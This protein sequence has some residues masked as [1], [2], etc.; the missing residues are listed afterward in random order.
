MIARATFFI[1]EMEQEEKKRKSDTTNYFYGPIGQYIERVEHNHFGMSSDGSFQYGDANSEVVQRKLFPDLPTRD[2]MISAVIETV[3]EGLWWSN[4]S[5]AIVYRIYQ[6]KGYMGGFSQFVR[7]VK[8]WPV[9]TGFECN[10]DA[11]QKPVTSGVLV[12]NPKDWEAQ[13]ASKQA[14]K[15]GQ[16]LKD[17]LE[18]KASESS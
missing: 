15:L 18:K 11:V 14:A 17:I 9:K 3:R 6:M 16:A 13:G 1:I 5:W 8:E 2:E 10:Y 4:R 12:G 7:E